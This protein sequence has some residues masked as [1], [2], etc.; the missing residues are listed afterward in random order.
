MVRFLNL[1]ANMPVSVLKKVN[2]LTEF[3]ESPICSA[4]FLFKTIPTK[5]SAGLCFRGGEWDGGRATR[6]IAA[7]TGGLATRCVASVT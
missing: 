1:T 6:E 5:K 3:K 2:Q 4:I 7:A